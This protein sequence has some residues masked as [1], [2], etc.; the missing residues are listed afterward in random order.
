MFRSLAAVFAGFLAIVILVLVSAPVTARVLSADAAPRP[1]SAYLT[2][3]LVS[4]FVC[5]GAGGW[6]AGHLAAAHPLWHAA[7]LAAVVLGLGVVTAAQGGAARAGQPS[8]YVWTLPFVG[9][10]G[11]MLGGWI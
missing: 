9:A 10:A 3:N 7:A 2:V 8:W 1:T 5:S 11:A 6:L 4:G